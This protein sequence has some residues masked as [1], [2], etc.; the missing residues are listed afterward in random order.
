[1]VYKMK[2]DYGPGNWWKK[3]IWNLK[4]KN[5]NKQLKNSV[6]LYDQQGDRNDKAECLWFLP[7]IFK[8]LTIPS[9]GKQ[10]SQIPV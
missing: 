9:T 1:M 4:K 2:C 8:C 6:R 5:K 10:M 7:H 3:F